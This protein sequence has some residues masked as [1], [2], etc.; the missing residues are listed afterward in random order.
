MTVARSTDPGQAD[1][2]AALVRALVDA[3]T[4]SD[5]ARVRTCSA[6][7]TS[8]PD[9]AAARTQDGHRRGPAQ[10]RMWSGL[11]TYDALGVATLGCTAGAA[12]AAEHAV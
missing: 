3:G 1:R 9:G 10:G 11:G 4:D 2:V 12:S 7:S 6:T 8:Q 5:A